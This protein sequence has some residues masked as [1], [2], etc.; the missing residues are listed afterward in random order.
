MS[1]RNR[2]PI[3]VRLRYE[4][5]AR[6]Q[7]ARP[8]TWGVAGAP[9]SG[10]GAARPS[11]SAVVNGRVID[12]N[13]PARHAASSLDS[14]TVIGTDIRSTVDD[15]GRFTL[16]GVPPGTVRLRF[17]GANVH[18]TVTIPGVEPRDQID[19][20]LRMDARHPSD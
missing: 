3:V 19:I 7:S 1:F 15:L 5:G 10:V 12:A 8:R 20:A 2:R 6:L 17:T 18:A 16:H 11:E 9:E 14:V 13:A 4:R